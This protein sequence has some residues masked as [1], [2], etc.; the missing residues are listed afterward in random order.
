MASGDLVA[1]YATNSGTS[2]I[3]N[4]SAVWTECNILRLEDEKIVEWWGAEDTLSQWRQFGFQIKE[5][6]K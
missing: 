4:Q 2:K 1:Y 5:P 3:Y 6:N